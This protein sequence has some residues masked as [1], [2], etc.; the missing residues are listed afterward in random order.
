MEVELNEL[1]LEGREY[2]YHTLMREDVYNSHPVYTAVLERTK[3]TDEELEAF[4]SKENIPRSGSIIANE[5]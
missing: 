5:G 2:Q 1:A 4:R 3:A